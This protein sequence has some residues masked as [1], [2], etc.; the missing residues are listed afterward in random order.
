MGLFDNLFERKECD[1]CGGK[2]GLLGGTKVKDGR[3]CKECAGKLSPHLT[4]L[5]NLTLDDI[6]EHLA[7]REENAEK[8]KAFNVTHVI[9]GKGAKLYLD[10][11]KKQIIVSS[12]TNW[13][14]SNPDILNFDQIVGN[15]LEIKENKKEIKKKGE[16]GKEVSY[17]PKRYEYSYNFY[18]YLDVNS[19]WFN[20]QTLKVNSSAV[21][22]YDNDVYEQCYIDSVEMC[23]VLDLLKNGETEQVDEAVSYYKSLREAPKRSYGKTY[24]T[25]TKK[26]SRSYSY[27]Y[28][29][30]PRK[31]HYK[32]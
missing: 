30:D 10:M 18:I 19:P 21:D 29:K 8:V 28:E 4:G 3:L 23:E 5:K 13:R 14:N 17:N 7:Y 24:Y 27:Y 26:Y 22:G 12:S 31:D 20:A 1:I 15:D 2:V 6:K 9:G 25:D 32:F 16:D 11:E